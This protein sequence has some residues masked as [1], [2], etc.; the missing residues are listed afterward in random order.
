MQKSLRIAII[1]D[2][3]YGPDRYSKKGDVALDL[4]EN[5][6]RQVNA[7]DVGLVVDLGDRI[8]NA[9]L[10][11]DREHLA[12]VGAAFKSLTKD[13][14]HIIGNHDV[15]HLS[16]ADH[17]AILGRSLHHH[18]LDMDGWHLVFWNASCK[19]HEGQGFRLEQ[20]DLDW[21]ATDLA[22]TDLP[23]VVFSH[24]PV[25]TGSMVGNYYFERRYT[26]GEQHRNAHLARRLIEG[27]EKV[28]AVVS[29]HVHW[30]QLHFM[31]GIPHF[32]LQSLSETFT[33]HPHAAGSWALLTLG[34]TVE[35]E[36]FGRDPV[37]Y[38]M[39]VKN[40]SHHWLAPME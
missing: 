14:R 25:D 18:S 26:H 11:T 1:T 8:S 31:D 30:N 27:S 6:I 13:R 32:S 34:D 12:R 28:I 17:E 38:R 2:I 16:I 3:H 40:T 10:L 19:L 33:T 7:M 29:G 24:M 15:V 20:E 5:F 22:A 35:L 23:S 36:V 37:M 4:L 21:L 9:D 39:P